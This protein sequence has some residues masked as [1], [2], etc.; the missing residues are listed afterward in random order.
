MRQIN[1]G[2]RKFPVPGHPFVSGR[3][4]FLL[5]LEELQHSARIGTL[6]APSG[7]ALLAIDIPLARRVHR[8]LT[9]RPG[10]WLHRN[11]PG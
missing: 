8:R 4:G 9:I 11:R 7:L 3:L 2:G 6:D 1:I 5:I 10:S